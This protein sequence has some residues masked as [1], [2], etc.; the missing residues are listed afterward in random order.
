[1]IYSN[2]LFCTTVFTR[3]PPTLSLQ[4]L[5][6]PCHRLRITCDGLW[7][8]IQSRHAL[9][10][11]GKIYI[12][13]HFRPKD[14]MIIS[15]S[16]VHYSVHTSFFK[17]PLTN[18]FALKILR[19]ALSR[20]GFPEGDFLEGRR[21][22]SKPGAS[23]STHYLFVISVLIHTH[24]SIGHHNETFLSMRF[25]N[26]VLNVCDL[27]PNTFSGNVAQLKQHDGC[28]WY[29]NDVIKWKLF[30]VTGHLCGEF[31]GPR[32]IPRTK[33]SDAELWCF[34]WSTSE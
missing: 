23:T 34:L 3:F 30:R 27:W 12:L 10:W 33:A 11:S 19:D 13:V 2:R 9:D 4:H 25:G 31:A 5:T 20:Q 15:I 6:S 32:W 24:F 8:W 29:H 14:D 21:F 1:M 18:Y 28:C 26:I 17:L 7:H 22:L 16:I